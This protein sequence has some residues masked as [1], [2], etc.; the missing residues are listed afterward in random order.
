MLKQGEA[1]VKTAELLRTHGISETTFTAGKRKF[2]GL[3]VSETLRLRVLEG[4]N[5]R[6]KR[7][8]AELSLNLGK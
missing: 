3:D 4:G 6:L 1:S 8:G 2:G 7:L 5:R